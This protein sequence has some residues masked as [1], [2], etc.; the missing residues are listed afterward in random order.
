MTAI[1][2]KAANHANLPLRAT[3]FVKIAVLPWEKRLHPGC[4]TKTLIGGQFIA[5]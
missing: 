1:T 2:P 4:E 5:F 3:R